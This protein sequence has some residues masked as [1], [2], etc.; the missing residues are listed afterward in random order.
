MKWRWDQGRLNYFNF[1]NISKMAKVLRMFDG[2]KLSSLDEALRKEMKTTADLSFKPENYTVWRNYARVFRCSIL[3]DEINGNLT[4]TQLCA[5]IANDEFTVDSY[6]AHFTQRFCYPSPIFF[7]SADISKPVYPII[8]IL[9]FLISR[10]KFAKDDHI[11]LQEIIQYLIGNKVSG[12]E[13]ITFYATLKPK[14]TFLSADEVRQL[15]EL[16]CFASQFSFLKWNNPH[17]IFD[18]SYNDEEIKKFLDLVITPY[19][20][21]KKKITSEVI[22]MGV[23]NNHIDYA[24]IFNPASYDDISYAEGNKKFVTHLRYER[25]ITLKKMFFSLNTKVM[26]CDMCR[27]NLQTKYDWTRMLLEL[28]HILPLS[29]SLRITGD[30]TS[31]SDLVAICPNCHKAT[32]VYYRLWLKDKNKNDFSDKAEALFV[33]EEVKAKVT[34]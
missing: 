26:E 20:T 28:H 5:K 6:M 2:R 29:S 24:P 25:S 21:T 8:A 23:V 4:C 9:K 14:N 30:R 13:D 27:T 17:L 34:K 32:H 1:S 7:E 10:V 18:E 3:A 22:A 31:L 19:I 12:L 16:V 11:T 33:Y 15:R